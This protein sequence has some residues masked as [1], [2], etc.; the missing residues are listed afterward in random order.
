[1]TDQWFVQARD[2]LLRECAATGDG[3]SSQLDR[4]PTDGAA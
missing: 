1:M 3:T 4:R 2:G